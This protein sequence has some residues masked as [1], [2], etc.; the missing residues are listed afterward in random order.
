MFGGQ[1][2]RAW[3]WRLVVA[4]GLA[5]VV[6]VGAGVAWP[7]ERAVSALTNCTVGSSSELDAAEQEFLYLINEYRADQNPP[8]PPLT[9]DPDLN[10]SAQ[11]LA[12]DMQLHGNIYHVEPYPPFRDALTRIVDCGETGIGWWSEIV[13][14]GARTG[15]QALNLWR[16]SEG[17]DCAI[18][19]PR[20][21]RVGI[22]KSG[23]YWAVD[24]TGPRFHAWTCSYPVPYTAPG[25]PPPAVATTATAPL[26]TATHTSTPQ[27]TN[28][29]EPTNTPQPTSVPTAVWYKSFAVGAT[30][31]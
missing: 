20:V 16:T 29:P 13:L 30:R 7:R 15:T 11:W 12:E 18:R 3:R 4:A 2:G 24:F 8:A 14:V 22:G 25:D 28:T 17:H 26:A 1:G 10:R 27:S 9:A 23:T 6:L 31:E 5:G 21:T 19:D